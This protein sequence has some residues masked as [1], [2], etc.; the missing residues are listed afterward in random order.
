ME[1]WMLLLGLIACSLVA[2][3][4]MA[5][6]AYRRA[7]RLETRFGLLRADF[8]R[9]E[10][11]VRR[12]GVG[13]ADAKPLATQ[14]EAA[15]AP[16]PAPSSA[17]PPK[18]PEEK[19][20][21]RAAQEPKPQSR[22]PA[23][24][25]PPRPASTGASGRWDLAARLRL[26]ESLTSR[27][28]VWLGGITIALGGV[29]LIKYSIDHGLLSPVFRILLG[30]LLGLSLMAG[31]EW[32]RRRPLQRAIARLKP[33]FVPLALT[34]AG[35]C[36]AF[37]SVYAGHALYG[38]Y[39][40]AVAFAALVAVSASALALSLLQGP[41][42]AVLGVLGAMIVPFLISLNGTSA[43]G[44]FLYLIAV[45]ASAVAIVRYKDWWWLV[46]LAIGGS[47]LWSLLW[48]GGTYW[49][50]DLLPLSLHLFAVLGLAFVAR[51]KE[52][53]GPKAKDSHTFDPRTWVVPQVLAVSTSAAVAFL[54]LLLVEQDAHRSGALLAALLMTSV[55]AVAALRVRAL[56]VLLP[57]GALLAV[58][59]LA[60]WDLHDAVLVLQDRTNA[61]GLWIF[62]DSY[63][64][65]SELRRF[66]VVSALVGLG[67]GAFAYYGLWRA[68]RPELW[69]ALSGAVPLVTVIVGYGRTSSFDSDLSWGAIGL[70]LS[71]VLT[72][73]AQQVAERRGQPRI[74]AALGIYV[75]AAFSALSLAATMALEM[76]WLTVAL[77]LN[78]AA[79]GWIHQRMKIALLRPAALVMAAAI[80]LRLVF[81][82]D[83]LGSVIVPRMDPLWVLYSYGLPAALFAAAAY[84]FRSTADDLLVTVLESAAL[85]VA[86]A[87]VNMMI[88]QFFGDDLASRDGYSL[89][90]QSLHSI[91]W[92]VSGTALYRR[93]RKAPRIV[94]AWG[95]R[96]LLGAATLQVVAL[97]VVLTN[98]LLTG[99]DVGGTVFFNK[100]LLA[101]L[102]PAVIGLAVLWLARQQGHERVLRAAAGLAFGLVFVWLTLEVRH[103]FQGGVLDVGAVSDAEGYSY[104]VAWMLY[105][106][107]LLALGVLLNESALRHAGLGLVL[108][109]VAKVF[110][111]DMAGLAGLYRAAS[112][113]GL[114]LSLVAIGFFYQRFFRP[115]MQ[116]GEGEVLENE[117]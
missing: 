95:A 113:L 77:S 83:L 34:G 98:P 25:P 47:L 42:V 63:G 40:A 103:L 46:A 73:A 89:L 72:L 6:L 87:T 109:V 117:T 51:P 48:I 111:W 24:L 64:E 60:S 3:P 28:L 96:L 12:A 70:A 75:L 54:M 90:E 59:V 14:P 114:G 1:G 106:G 49:I 108:L 22:I 15:K 94:T 115:Q 41:F 79:A 18:E 112:F 62:L 50:G 56:E 107:A 53:I 35:L 39:S 78:L 84:W 86:V 9:L 31:G 7:G 61:I 97:Q 88:R 102:V 36:I 57:L 65:F 23:T 33:D 16:P 43:W 76:S 105:A 69:A 20:E 82:Q 5:V 10:E 101:Y 80:L 91:A 66:L 8:K 99:E 27:W 29:F 85:G 58:A 45:T 19:P 11:K 13:P 21:G 81:V 30:M 26:E 55:L 71:G 4:A 116:P 17:K 92:L 32:L 74:E 100:L 68:P 104:S 44:L 52:L 2:S 38:L 37:G 93:N 110:I 67:F